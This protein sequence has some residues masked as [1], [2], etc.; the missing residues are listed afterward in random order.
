MEICSMQ[1]M[2]EIKKKDY[3]DTIAVIFVLTVVV[4]RPEGA[5]EVYEAGYMS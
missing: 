5:R 2:T 1:L 3:R 4:R